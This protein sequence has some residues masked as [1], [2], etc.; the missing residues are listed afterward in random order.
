M[1]CRGVLLDVAAALGRRLLA[2]A[3]YEITADDLERGAP[4]RRDR[5]ETAVTWCSCDR[6]GDRCGRRCA[7]YVGRDTGVPGVGEAGAV[8]LADRQPA[9]RRR[10]HHRVRVP[11]P[12]RGPRLLPAHRVLLVETGI[13]IIESLDL[14]EVAAA[15]IVEFVFVL[16]PLPLVGAT[17]SPVRPL[18]VVAG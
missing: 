11:R 18:A 2:L 14:D 4:L 13:N 16:A 12:R 5:A 9:C 3:G 7:A 17:G 1:V 15:G 6:A 10:R 8:W